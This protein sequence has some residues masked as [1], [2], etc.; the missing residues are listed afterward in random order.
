MK[1]LA[2]G[3][4][5]LILSL[6]TT[7]F[8]ETAL[9]K[10][11]D[12]QDDM[13]ALRNGAALF[14]DYCLSCHSLSFVRYNRLAA[15]GFSDR[16]IREMMTTA[17]SPG[18]P[19]RIAARMADQ[20]RWFGAA[21][22]DLSLVAR[23]RA[24]DKGSGADWLYAYMRSF[25]RDENRPTG[26]NN[27]VLANVAMPHVLWNVQDAQTTGN[28]QGTDIRKIPSS[29][30]YDERIAELAGFLVWAGEPE[31]AFRKRTGM[32]VM[33]FLFVFLALAYALKKDYW[34]EIENEKIE[35]N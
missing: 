32:G 2:A 25:H 13:A 17:D 9:R 15:L 3:T 21:P 7:V 27:T 20:K 10:A 28:G 30:D 4:F 24:S 18:E 6:S 1:T 29:K 19:M 33:A 22:P 12:V 14:I 11:P 8:G 16:Q 34:R 26:W 23:S 31:A 5:F 35:K